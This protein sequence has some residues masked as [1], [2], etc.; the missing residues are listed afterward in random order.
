MGAA[1]T[2]GKP[3]AVITAIGKASGGYDYR[4]RHGIR[5]HGGLSWRLWRRRCHRLR[6]PPRRT[7][8]S[9][10]GYMGAYDSEYGDRKRLTSIYGDYGLRYRLRLRGGLQ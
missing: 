8:G 6:L 2:T 7:Y 5:L 10:Y 9:D 3:T 1:L 4:L